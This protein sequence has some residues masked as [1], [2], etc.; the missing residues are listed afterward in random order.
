MSD[1]PCPRYAELTQTAMDPTCGS[2]GFTSNTLTLVSICSTLNEQF[3]HS[4][5]DCSVETE[6][7]LGSIV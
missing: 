5:L 4:I 6:D 3:D 7:Y 2:W 1:S